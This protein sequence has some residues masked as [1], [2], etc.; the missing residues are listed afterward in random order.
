MRKP[1]PKKRDLLDFQYRE[2]SETGMQEGEYEELQQQISLLENAE[3]L[4]E[5]CSSLNSLLYDADNAIYRHSV[6]PQN[7]QKNSQPLTHGSMK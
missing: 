2:L 1:W 5:L 4:A 7:S 3:T 6:Q